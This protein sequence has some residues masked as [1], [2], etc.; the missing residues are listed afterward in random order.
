MFQIAECYRLTKDPRKA[1]AQYR[2]LIRAKYTDP[3]ASL[4]MAEAMRDQEKYEMAIKEYKN[5]I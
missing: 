2:R 3:I 1:E 4:Y 5:Y